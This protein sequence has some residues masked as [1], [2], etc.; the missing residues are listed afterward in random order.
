MSR[1]GRGGCGRRHYRSG[2]LMFTMSGPSMPYGE[3]VHGGHLPCVK[4][5]LGYFHRNGRM[6][7]RFHGPVTN[8]LKIPTLINHVNLIKIKM[9]FKC[10]LR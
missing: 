3:T 8:K 5:S 7:W 2:E 4:P 6:F 1:T 9:L 10:E